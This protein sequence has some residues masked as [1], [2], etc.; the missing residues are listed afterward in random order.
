MVQ[1]W[2]PKL[3][4]AF[5]VLLASRHGRRRPASLAVSGPACFDKRPATAT[6]AN[7]QAAGGVT[8]FDGTRSLVH[9]VIDEAIRSDAVNWWKLANRF[10][11]CAPARNGGKV[12]CTASSSTVRA[13]GNVRFGRRTSELTFRV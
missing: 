3:L 8:V 2:R 11:V 12:R 1:N 10:K 5:K 4:V 6:T 13:L 9:E 7:A